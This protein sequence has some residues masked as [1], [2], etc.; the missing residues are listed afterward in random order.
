V[1]T[2]WRLRTEKNKNWC[3]NS[4]KKQECGSTGGSI[5]S[6]TGRA[7]VKEESPVATVEG[8]ADDMQVPQ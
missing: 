3:S 7:L 8:M 4:R 2:N 6:A 5:Y 1:I